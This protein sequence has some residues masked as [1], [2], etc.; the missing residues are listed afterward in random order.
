MVFILFGLL[1]SPEQPRLTSVSFFLSQPPEWWSSRLTSKCSFPNV[2]ECIF[3]VSFPMSYL[4]LSLLS[5]LATRW[6]FTDKGLR[7]G[8]IT[9]HICDHTASLRM[10]SNP[11][12][13]PPNVGF[14]YSKTLIR[15]LLKNALRKT[16]KGVMA[17]AFI[18]EDGS[19][20]WASL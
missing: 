9:L 10:H 3:C 16:R 5:C 20:A 1:S 2:F 19:V 8:E 13:V 12:T 7:D 17:I 18:Q 4:I 15:G 14:F 11:G 6:P